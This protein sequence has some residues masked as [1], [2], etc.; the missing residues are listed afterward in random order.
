MAGW[1][2][3]SASGI[4]QQ[5]RSATTAPPLPMDAGCTITEAGGIH[6]A[7]HH[8][9][10]PWRAWRI[11][12]EHARRPS[13]S[14]RRH[15]RSRAG[16]ERRRRQQASTQKQQ[17]PMSGG[18][19]KRSSLSP[20]TPSRSR[21]EYPVAGVQ[22][23]RRGPASSACRA[24]PAVPVLERMLKLLVISIQTRCETYIRRNLPPGYH[25]ESLSQTMQGS[26]AAHFAPSP[27]A[28]CGLLAALTR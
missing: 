21:A 18:G 4:E 13:P 1:W 6:V 11:Y 26:H 9:C 17:L 7:T 20:S 12:N 27:Y 22:S 19:T 5:H 16:A 15:V 23:G 14:A 8:R 3:A 28:A 10:G 25:Q 24:L 2:G